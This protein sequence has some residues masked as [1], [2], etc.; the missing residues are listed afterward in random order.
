MKST[1]IDNSTLCD[2]YCRKHFIKGGVCIFV[3]DNISSSK[4]NLESYCVDKD[5]EACAS[6]LNFQ[7]NKIYIVT[8]YRSPS[9]NFANFMNHLEQRFPSGGSRTPGGSRA[10]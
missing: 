4:F 2:F 8:I 6:Q 1:T 9:G 5:F 3:D 10:L 7:K